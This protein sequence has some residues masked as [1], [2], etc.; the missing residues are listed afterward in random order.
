MLSLPGL[1]SAGRFPCIRG[2]RGSSVWLAARKGAGW[3]VGRGLGRVEDWPGKGLL[4]K[5]TP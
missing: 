4:A 5:P 1:G 3:L 2:S